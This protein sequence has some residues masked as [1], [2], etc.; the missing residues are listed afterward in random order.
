MIRFK[1]GRTWL[2]SIKKK[3]TT[4]PH[5]EGPDFILE[6]NPDGPAITEGEL[7]DLKD[8]TIE[9]HQSA[10]VWWVKQKQDNIEFAGM[11]EA[12]D[13]SLGRIRA[14]LKELGLKRTL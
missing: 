4:I 11:V 7:N 8:D 6:P 9:A 3:L 1:A 2:K 14:K 12:T 13:Q 5:Q 10:R